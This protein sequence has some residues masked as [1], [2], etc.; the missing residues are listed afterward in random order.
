MSS[1]EG[2]TGVGNHGAALATGGSAMLASLGSEVGTGRFLCHFDPRL[3]EGETH[4]PG[5]FGKRVRKALKTKDGS[6]EKSDKRV[7]ECARDW[8]ERR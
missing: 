7:Q 5:C 4:T 3:G 6:G 1:A 8:R 2:A